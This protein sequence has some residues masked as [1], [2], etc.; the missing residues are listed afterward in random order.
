MKLFRTA[1]PSKAAGHYIN[2]DKKAFQKHCAIT[3]YL[4]N[5]NDKLVSTCLHDCLLSKKELSMRGFP[6]W[7]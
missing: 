5:V 2:P 1:M 3:H 6:T 4:T 7:E